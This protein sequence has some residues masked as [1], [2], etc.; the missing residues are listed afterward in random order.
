MGHEV[1][2]ALLKHTQQGE[3]ADEW[4]EIFRGGAKFTSL[5]YSRALETDADKVGLSRM[6]IAGYDGD[7][8]A[9]VWQRMAAFSGRELPEY[10]STHPSHSR[11]I[12]NLRKELPVAQRIA[13]K[14]NN[15]NSARQF[16][17]KT[18]SAGGGLLLPD[19]WT[20]LLGTVLGGAAALDP[21]NQADNNIAA[22]WVVG[23]NL[24]FD[25]KFAELNAAI[26][27]ANPGTNTFLHTDTVNFLVG[28][29]FKYPFRISDNI[30]E[31]PYIGV[32]Y[33]FGNNLGFG[34][35]V[36]F[37]TDFNITERLYVRNTLGVSVRLI[38]VGD[39]QETTVLF[40]LKL[41]L[42]YAFR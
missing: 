28:A 7:E 29:A 35:N 4:V 31:F 14:V 16:V 13:A 15:G 20:P 21:E 6:V 30:T 41:V 39:T 34:T 33:G 26:F 17:E 38:D 19:I 8:A 1:A 9:A 25:A 27:P 40:P 22:L 2:H 11:R 32:D 23:G 10:L 3:K 24:F 18:F 36:G 37:G 42:G 5:A 12:A